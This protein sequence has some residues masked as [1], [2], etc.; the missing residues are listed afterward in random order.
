VEVPIHRSI[1]TARRLVDWHVEVPSLVAM[2][3]LIHRGLPARHVRR[4]RR[5]HEARHERLLE[6]VTAVHV[7]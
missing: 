6:A 1:R 2:A 4:A 5:V 7:A 3:E